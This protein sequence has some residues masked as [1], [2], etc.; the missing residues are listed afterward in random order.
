MSEDSTALAGVEAVSEEPEVEV[1]ETESQPDTETENQDD[2]GEGEGEQEEP[3]EEIEFDFGGNKKKW[4]KGTPIEQIADEIS[5]FTKGTWSDYTRKSQE[6]AERA[7]ALEAREGAVEKLV[8]LQGETLKTYSR[9]LM[10]REE[11]EQLKKVD[12]NALWQSDA[13]QARRVSDL[14]SQKQAE[15]QSIVNTVAQNEQELTRA[16]QSEIARRMDEGKQ[17]VEKRIKGFSDKEITEYAVKCGI[18]K[19]DASK[20]ALNPVVTEAF[21]KAMHYDRMQAGAS[22]APKPNVQPAAPVKPL[23]GKGGVGQKDVTNM[24]P[25]EMAKHLGLRG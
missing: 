20:W 7:K 4:A 22:K 1:E 21:W 3:V 19:E 2:P 23:R 16:Q 17:L 6:N 25:A 24:T 11:I 10:V 14:L 8:G 15:F 13:D 12:L 18:P 5:Q 9:G